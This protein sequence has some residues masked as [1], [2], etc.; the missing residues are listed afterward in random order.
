MADTKKIIIFTGE[1][2]EFELLDE[3]RK[4]ELPVAEL[5]N[6]LKDFMAAF[7]EILPIAEKP[8]KG[9]GL[10]TVSSSLFVAVAVTRVSL[11]SS[12]AGPIGL[13][14]SSA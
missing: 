4:V 6:N 7:G 5:K 10:K 13:E 9:L 8:A 12:N 2:G 1:T 3:K 11:A 14:L